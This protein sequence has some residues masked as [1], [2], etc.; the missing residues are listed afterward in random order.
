MIHQA[1][2]CVRL[3]CRSLY[4][5]QRQGDQEQRLPILNLER[6]AKLAKTD[7]SSIVWS[8]AAQC[9]ASCG[10]TGCKQPQDRASGSAGVSGGSSSCLPLTEVPRFRTSDD[11]RLVL[12]M[13]GCP[14]RSPYSTRPCSR[15]IGFRIPTLLLPCRLLYPRYIW[16]CLPGPKR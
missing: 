2:S 11:S 7:S 9:T 8:R 13:A 10:A 6:S 1:S 14:C 3:Y 4:L 16:L 5:G 15:C 12:P